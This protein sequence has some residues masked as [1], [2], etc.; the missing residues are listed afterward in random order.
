MVTPDEEY[1][2][3]VRDPRTPCKFGVE[4]YQRNPLHHQKY[5]HPPKKRSSEVIKQRLHLKLLYLIC[6]LI[7]LRARSS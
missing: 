3:Y 4:C 1:D 2:Q 7:I 5:K 6:T